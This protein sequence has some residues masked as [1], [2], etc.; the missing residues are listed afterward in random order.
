[1]A[2]YAFRV[3]LEDGT[4]LAEH[5]GAML[6]QLSPWRE[7]PSRT[8]DLW[9]VDLDM[10]RKLYVAGGLRHKIGSRD[11]WIE[12]ATRGD[13]HHVYLCIAAAAGLDYV[14]VPMIPVGVLTFGVA[15]FSSPCVLA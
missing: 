9:L 7:R 2:V 1:N 5:N 12:V 14:R 15:V 3:L 4:V 11:A 6:A 13:P 10:E 8:Q